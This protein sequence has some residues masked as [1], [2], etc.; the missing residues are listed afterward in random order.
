MVVASSLMTWV[1][2]RQV[3]AHNLFISKLTCLISTVNV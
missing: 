3:P 1:W 2:A